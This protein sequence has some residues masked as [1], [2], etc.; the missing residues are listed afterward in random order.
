LSP[1][2]IKKSIIEKNIFTVHI[3]KWTNSNGA[4]KN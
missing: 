4:P 2:W 1:V 3:I